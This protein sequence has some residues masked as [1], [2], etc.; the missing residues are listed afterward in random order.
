MSEALKAGLED[1]LETC[2]R[3]LREIGSVL[4]ACSGGVDSTLLLKLAVDELGARNVLAVTAWGVIYP[5]FERDVARRMCGHVGA[6]L[7][8]IEVAQEDDPAF[9]ANPTDRCYHCKKKLFGRL[10]ELA[11][12]RDLA[13]VVSGANADDTGDY[14]P[15]M[16]AEEELGIRR[17]LLE[18]GIGKREIR[19]AS[20][21][22]HLA[23]WESPSMACLAS[24]IPYGKRITREK[25]ERI[26]RAEE[27]LRGLGFSQYRV[28]DH[29]QVARIEVPPEEISRL[30]E[31]RGEV[32]AA[33]RKLGYAYVAMDME[34]YRTG[35]LNETLD[36]GNS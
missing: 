9:A 20:R 26:G 11:R 28:R 34:G 12:E 31:L 3:I 30:V 16:R 27:M 25:L 36:A 17:P 18:A 8:E 19:A 5:A 15:G 2:R 33:L 23:T 29:E 1:K 13:A 6:E 10:R 24:R 35:S 14:R 4:V 21:Q 7:V 22:M 32:A